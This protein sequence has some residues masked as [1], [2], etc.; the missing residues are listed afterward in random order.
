M[1]NIS[2]KLTSLLTSLV[3]FVL[4]FPPKISETLYLFCTNIEGSFLAEFHA[5]CTFFQVMLQLQVWKDDKSSNKYAMEVRWKFKKY[6]EVAKT[7]KTGATI[8]L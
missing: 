1:I 4:D 8:F 7:T 6:R 5:K 3:T 2:K